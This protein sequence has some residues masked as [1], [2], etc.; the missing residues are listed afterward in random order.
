MRGVFALRGSSNTTT[1]LR[2]GVL[3][4]LM[5]IACE[6]SAREDIQFNIDI[7]DLTDRTNIDLSQFSRSGFILPGIYTMRVQINTLVLPE[8]RIA[9]YPPDDAPKGSQACLSASLVDQLGL[10][11]NKLTQLG[12]WKEG[13]CLDIRSLS[14]ME[15]SGDLGTST[16]YVSLPQAYLEYSAQNWDPPSRWDE[17]VPGLLVDYNLTAQSINQRN[18]ASRTDLTGNGTFG[19]N[20]GPW[21]LRADWQGR[22]EDETVNRGKSLEWSRFYA[23]RALP[24]I[25]SRLALGQNYL[26]SDLFDSFRITGVALNSD[27]SQLPPN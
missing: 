6:V 5:S 2:T 15:V 17:G 12:W 16:L 27:D 23:Y 9:F 11:S 10:K 7:L 14:G 21:R 19:A 8:Q 26:Y 25:Q 24:S 13:E 18:T 1:I 22:I 3:S 20:A 4:G